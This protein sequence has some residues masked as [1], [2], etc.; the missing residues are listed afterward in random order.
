M[1]GDYNSMLLVYMQHFDVYL[2]MVKLS[3]QCSDFITCFHKNQHKEERP[4]LP[5]CF[6]HVTGTQAP[7]V[8]MI[9]FA[10]ESY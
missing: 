4:S 6:A 1:A 10:A 7:M 5:S 2:A 8:L 9:V 3:F